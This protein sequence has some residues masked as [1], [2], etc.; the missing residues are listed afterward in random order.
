MAAQSR[1]T[2]RRRG[3]PCMGCWRHLI[4]A[5]RGMCRKIVLYKNISRKKNC[6][7]LTHHMPCAATWPPQSSQ[8]TP[9]IPEPCAIDLPSKA[10]WALCELVGVLCTLPRQ[11]APHARPSAHVT[12]RDA[13][14]GTFQAA[15]GAWRGGGKGTTCVRMKL[16]SQPLCLGG[17]IKS[18]N[19]AAP[20]FCGMSTVLLGVHPCE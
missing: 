7:V 3:R 11:R 4:L 10:L 14:A 20:T 17:Q 12:G 15:H 16:V 13:R 6:L 2:H 18:P 8:A 1:S 19:S 9:P 5:H